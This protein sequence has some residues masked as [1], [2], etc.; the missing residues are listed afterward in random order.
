MVALLI[1]FGNGQHAGQLDAIKVAGT[2]VLGTGG[3]AAL[4]LTARRQ[5]ISEIALNQKAHDQHHSEQL[6]AFQQQQAVDTRAHL[7]RVALATEEDARERRITDLY[8]KA[9]DQLG[10]DKAPVRL[11][12]LYA[13]ER[14]AQDNPNQRQM[15]VNVLCAY[16][17]L[18][19]SPPNEKKQQPHRRSRARTGISPSTPLPP[20]HH[21]EEELLVRR[22]AQQIL[23]THLYTSDKSTEWPRLSSPTEPAFWPGITLNLAGATLVDFELQGEVASANFRG[24]RFTGVANFAHVRFNQHAMFTDASFADGPA[25]FYGAWF[26]LRTSFINVDFGADEAVFKEA[27]FCGI[28]FFRGAKFR[29]GVTLKDGRALANFNK[30]WGD[31]REWPPGWRERPLGP[32]EQMPQTRWTRWS[33]KRIQPP[34]E[35][36]TWAAVVL[37]DETT[38]VL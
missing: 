35:D 3:A 21:P 32:D 8:T 31:T 27:T 22:T 1:F 36:G 24:A 7:E 18:P 5:R 9:A 34:A 17:R 26:G 6:F 11:A 23:T 12:G 13:L 20:R 16:L 30:N 29:G 14:L 37:S 25:H 15:I 10:S 38:P 19:Y 33:Q 4:W 2:V 28:T